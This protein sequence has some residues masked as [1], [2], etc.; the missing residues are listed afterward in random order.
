MKR[1][2]SILTVFVTLLM[3][4]FGVL[5]GLQTA[6]ETVSAAGVSYPKQAVNF[7]AYV[8]NRNLNLNGTKL[9]TQ[10]AAGA[11]TENWYIEYVSSGVYNIVSASDG[12]YLTASGTNVITAGKSGNA[13][14]NWQIVSV[15]KDFEGYDLYYKILNA[16]TG[17]ALTYYQGSNAVGLAAFN[18]DGAQQWKLNLFGQEGFSANTKVAGGEKAATIGGVLGQT[19]YVSTADDLEKQLNS[20]GAQTIVITADIDMQKKGNTRI[21]DNKT[22]IGSYSKNTI[23]DSQFRTNDAYGAVDDSP[24]DNIIFYNLNMVAKNV[25]NRILI[26]IW[27]SR[28]IWVDH[29]T[30]TSQLS[31]DRKGNGQDEVGKFIWLNTPYDNYMDAKDLNRSPDYITISYCKFYNRYW[32]VAYGTQNGETSRCRTTLC[33]NKWDK[34]VRR[35]PQIGNGN[36][37]I[38]NNYYEGY[39]N[40]NG[41]GTSQIIGGDGSNIVS[42]NCRFQSYENTYPY[43]ISAGGGNDPYRDS[44]SYYAKTSGATPVVF[45]IS[46]KVTSTWYPN[47]EN[48]GYKLIPAYNTNNTDTKTFCNTY[49][50]CFNSASGIKYIRDSALAKFVQTT[51]ESP[52]LTDKFNS[53]F[54]NMITEFKAATLKEGAVY[55]FKNVNSGLYMEV[56]SAKAADGT[57]VQQWGAT[58]PASH[59]TWRVLSA[60]DGYYYVYSQ[61][62]DKVTYLLDVANGKADNGT[63]IGI[64]S[65]T[66]AD[67]QQFKFYQHTDGSYFILTKASKDQSCVAVSSASKNAGESVIEWAVNLEDASQKWTL[68]EVAD[69]GCKM[70]TSKVY[71]FKNSNRGLYMEVANASAKDNANVQQWGVSDVSSHN[72]WTLKE[73]AGG[74]GYYYIISQL[75]DGKTYYLNSTGGADGANIEIL[76]NNKTSSHLFKFVKNPDGSYYILTRTSKDAAAVEIANADKT[77]GAN[78]QHWSVNGNACQKWMAEAHA[79]TTTTTTAKATTTTT[80]TTTKATTAKTTT[81][82]AITTTTTTTKAT[83]TTTT[84]EVTTTTAEPVVTTTKITTTVATTTESIAATT[85]ESVATTKTTIETTATAASTTTEIA[86]TEETTDT[87]QIL[88]TTSTTVVIDPEDTLYGD[89]NLDGKVELIDAILLNKA[90]A[91]AVTLSP[92]AK[93]N[94]DCHVDGITD[95]NDAIV[96]LRF[97]V[98]LVNTLPEID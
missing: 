23:Y 71:Q 3:A 14:Q 41:S 47:K 60:G 25:P 19:V 2:I 79:V 72:S 53:K 66:K 30:F 32:T 76:T 62:G 81:A 59:N 4:M 69:T 73:F 52:F 84:I 90:A 89:V 83:T 21:R 20:V 9:N 37:H 70:D 75:G 42:E 61:V 28:Q 55:M 58:E 27:S 43:G 16:S 5:T 54:G 87:T 48:Y 80:T 88:E 65:D 12:S 46:P 63:N 74:G 26:N 98:H 57:N 92:E 38:Y 18:G 10:K 40:D 7:G 68:E 96:L 93:K 82:K 86:A 45:S 85:T 64:W 17:N 33:Y 77:S 22:I 39:D 94:G 11:V 35:C 95:T 97:L 78:V 8:T 36:G 13:A 29:C 50:G 34:N 24:S 51:Y 6:T 91:G 44:G 49:S 15:T 31:Y 1:T 67:A 56:D